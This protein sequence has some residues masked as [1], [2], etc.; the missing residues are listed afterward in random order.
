MSFLKSFFTQ[1]E[2]TEN[3]DFKDNMDDSD[4]VKTEANGVSN[5]LSY[6]RQR[7][8]GLA[9]C[10]KKYVLRGLIFSYLLF[11]TAMLFLISHRNAQL[12]GLIEQFENKNTALLT[13]QIDDMYT[14]LDKLSSSTQN[15]PQ[16]QRALTQLYDELS[17]LEKNIPSIAKSE[18]LKK[19]S[20]DMNT[21][22]DH[23]EKTVAGNSEHKKYLDAKA[24]PFQMISI[25]VIAQQAFISVEFDHRIIPLGVGDTLSGWKVIRL[26]YS[27]MEAEF[28]NKNEEFVKLNLPNSLTTL[29]DKIG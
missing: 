22:F 4:S 28:V 6:L 1:K 14:R 2:N 19:M 16:T 26:D 9:I 8:S 25:D 10:D 5:G 23:L 29:N 13:D 18:E 24:L 27:A 11:L 17:L 12:F 20:V 15:A 3:S 21:H 7:F